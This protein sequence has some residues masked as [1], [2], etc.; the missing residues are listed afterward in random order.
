MN[1][2]QLHNMLN[3]PSCDLLDGNIALRNLER[4]LLQLVIIS[5]EPKA[6]THEK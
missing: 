2:N 1:P 6:I 3:E 5:S 4:E